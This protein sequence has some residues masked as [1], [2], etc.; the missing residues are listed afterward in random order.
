MVKVF[1]LSEN[2]SRIPDNSNSNY[3]GYTIVKN[4]LDV[5]TSVCS[6]TRITDFQS[7]IKFHE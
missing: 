4:L 1:E 5:F 7:V 6:E 3:V 2:S